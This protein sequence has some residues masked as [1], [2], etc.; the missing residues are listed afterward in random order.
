MPPN[1]EAR[2]VHCQFGSVNYSE[3][4]GHT[5]GFSTTKVM[6]GLGFDATVL[7]FIVNRCHS[8]EQPSR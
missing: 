5:R 3:K 2:I 6:G 1:G 7:D 8:D 4:T